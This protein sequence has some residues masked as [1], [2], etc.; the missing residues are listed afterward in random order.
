M[1]NDIQYSRSWITKLVGKAYADF[2]IDFGNKFNS[3]SLTDNEF[4]LLIPFVLTAIG[5]FT[6]VMSLNKKR[7]FLLVNFQDYNDFHESPW[8]TNIHKIYTQA[9]MHEMK[10]NKRSVPFMEKLTRVKWLILVKHFDIHDTQYTI[11]LCF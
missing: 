2:M 3:L 9:L 5:N 11:F 4:A 7:S 8:I 6:L 1:P 10:I